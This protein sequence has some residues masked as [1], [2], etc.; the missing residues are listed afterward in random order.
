[1]PLHTLAIVMTVVANLG[2]H[3][4]QRTIRPDAHPLA[5]LVAS[6]LTALLV[7]ALAWP[8]F[9]GGITLGAAARSLG[10]TSFA[11]GGAIVLLELGFLLAYRAGWNIGV[12]ALYSNASVAL[13]LVPIGAL[14][15]GESLDT[16]RLLG[17]GFAMVG[18]FLLTP[19]RS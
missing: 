4:F 8:F 17:F 6:Y 2:Y 10:W 12:A 1:M 3:L 14:A 11:L 5:S 18:L 13:L 9:A 15:F 19:T 7:C 16:R